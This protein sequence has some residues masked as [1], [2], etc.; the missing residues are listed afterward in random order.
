MEAHGAWVKSMAA[1]SAASRADDGRN[2]RGKDKPYGLKEARGRTAE[3][4]CEGRRSDSIR[5]HSLGRTSS[6]DNRRFKDLSNLGRSRVL[7]MVNK[8]LMKFG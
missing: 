8:M 6:A 2:T 1:R 3:L 4:V 7:K 5:D